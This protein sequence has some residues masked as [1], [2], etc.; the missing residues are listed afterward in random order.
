M[1]II[2]D[3]IFKNLE[4]HNPADCYEK[5]FALRTYGFLLAQEEHTRMEGND[6][7]NQS[8]EFQSLHPYWAERKTNLFVPIMTIDEEGLLSEI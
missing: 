1:S 3:S 8:E 2:F 7:I 6:Y 5:V 4:K